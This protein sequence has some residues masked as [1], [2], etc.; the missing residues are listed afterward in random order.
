ME[1]ETQL[2][3]ALAYDTS[4]AIAISGLVD[5]GMYQDNAHHFYEA[6]RA[7]WPKVEEKL[8]QDYTEEQLKSY[9]EFAQSFSNLIYFVAKKIVDA[10]EEAQVEASHYQ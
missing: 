8:L 1:S 4:L 5:E 10:V 7:V 2:V 9:T 6:G 3:D